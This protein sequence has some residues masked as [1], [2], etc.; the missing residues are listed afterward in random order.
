VKADLSPRPES[1]HAEKLK[2]QQH[3]KMQ[4]QT[5][6]LAGL[7]LA[8]G[9]AADRMLTT[10]SCPNIGLGACNSQ[11]EWISAY[12]NFF[13]DANEGCRDP[14]DVPGMWSIC[15]DWGNGRAHFFFDGQ[16][17]RCLKR[18]GADFDVGPCADTSRHCSRQWWE[19]VAC[20]W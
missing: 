2:A 18:T 10:T 5:P 4:L 11:G 6:L 20:T 8:T 13:L 9:A 12:G 1:R 16:A 17:K 7:A 14:P 19:E 3:T 15:M